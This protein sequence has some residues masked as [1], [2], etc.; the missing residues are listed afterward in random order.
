MSHHLYLI[1]EDFFVGFVESVEFGIGRKAEVV[2][3][4]TVE[5]VDG[6]VDDLVEVC[7]VALHDFLCVPSLGVVELWRDVDVVEQVESG[8]DRYGMFHTVSPVLC[9]TGFHDFVL[10]G[11]DAVADISCISDRYLLV[12]LF[13][14]SQFFL[15]ERVELCERYTHV[16]HGEGQCGVF[17]VL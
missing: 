3:I 15:L 4:H 10:F 2:V 9:Q 14:S 16:W 17:H 8:T 1:T 11:G 7:I 13:L 12:P 6:V 5:S